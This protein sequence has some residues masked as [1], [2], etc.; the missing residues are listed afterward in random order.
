MYVYMLDVARQ[1]ACIRVVCE[2]IKYG[3]QCTSNIIVTVPMQ[4]CNYYIHINGLIRGT[5][6]QFLEWLQEANGAGWL[7]TCSTV[8][9]VVT[10]V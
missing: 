5:T 3:D 8:Q 7:T 9:L 4:C 2:S 1:Q 10:T 6:S